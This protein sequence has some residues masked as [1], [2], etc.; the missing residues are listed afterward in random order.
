MSV[1]VTDEHV[2]VYFQ[3]YLV[4]DVHRSYIWRA[5]SVFAWRKFQA[6]VIRCFLRPVSFH[7][8]GSGC[9]KRFF[10]SIES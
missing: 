9:I 7:L 10:P 6:T 2:A 3:K 5:I 4:A 8:L 1:A